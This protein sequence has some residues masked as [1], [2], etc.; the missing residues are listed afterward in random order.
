MSSP[1][2]PSL[3]VNLSARTRLSGN[4][5]YIPPGGMRQDRK[6]ILRSYCA[7]QPGC[8]CTRVR[9][10]HLRRI[11]ERAGLLPSSSRRLPRRPWTRCPATRS[12]GRSGC[13]SFTHLA[14]PVHHRHCLHRTR[15]VRP[16]TPHY[17][18]WWVPRSEALVLSTREHAKSAAERMFNGCG[19]EYSNLLGG[20]I[21]PD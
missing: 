4:I 10:F 7:E 18:P 8:R 21:R 5:E 20:Q 11:V 19:R 15:Q 1:A 9:Q 17:C 14:V 3:R 16:P 6:P 12:S 13:T 2:G